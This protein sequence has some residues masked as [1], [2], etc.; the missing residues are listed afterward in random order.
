MNLT[1]APDMKA[2]QTCM[3][4]VLESLKFREGQG[5]FFKSECRAGEAAH[6]ANLLYISFCATNAI[7]YHELKNAHKAAQIEIVKRNE[8]P[9]CKTNFQILFP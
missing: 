6:I 4:R 8:F 5:Y 9:I 3:R 2:S 7:I 1:A